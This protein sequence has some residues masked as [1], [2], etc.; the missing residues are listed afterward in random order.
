MCISFDLNHF[1]FG[2]MSPYVMQLGPKT[3]YPFLLFLQTSLTRTDKEHTMNHKY[4][5][6]TLLAAINLD[7]TLIITRSDVEKKND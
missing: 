3:L 6:C 7:V 1:P 4:H 2:N 5:K